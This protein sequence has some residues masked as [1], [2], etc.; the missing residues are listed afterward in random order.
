MNKEIGTRRWIRDLLKAQKLISPLDA[1][2]YFVWFLFQHSLNILLSDAD[3][4]HSHLFSS[5]A[6]SILSFTRDEE[7]CSECV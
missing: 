5:T 1:V 4:Y 6:L 3:F 2:L 7:Y